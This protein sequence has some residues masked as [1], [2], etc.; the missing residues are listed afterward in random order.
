MKFATS[1]ILIK[2]NQ[3]LK[4]NG[5]VGG[6]AF[7]DSTTDYKQLHFLKDAFRHGAQVKDYR[8]ELKN[9]VSFNDTSLDQSHLST[10]SDIVTGAFRW[11]VNEPQKDLVGALLFNKLSKMCW[12]IKS[13]DGTLHVRD[14]GICIRPKKIKLREYEADVEELIE[15]LEKYASAH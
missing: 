3:F 8:V 1:T 6:A 9:I 15:R 11:A 4:E 14:R 2:F 5:N 10:V 7:L 13:P 12:G